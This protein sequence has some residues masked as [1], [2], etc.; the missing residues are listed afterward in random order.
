MA[1]I[2]DKMKE[3]S[4][5]AIAIKEV[6]ENGKTEAVCP[7]CGGKIHVVVDGG[8]YAKA[9]C[10]TPNCLHLTWRGI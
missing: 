3:Y 1:S 6:L 9:E 7:R 8:T 5:L 4:A 2:D 10:M